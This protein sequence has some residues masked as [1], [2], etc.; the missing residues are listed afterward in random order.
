MGAV[1]REPMILRALEPSI[2][3]SVLGIWM[4]ILFF[5]VHLDLSRKW[6]GRLCPQYVV[7]DRG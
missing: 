4:K 7:A 3:G 5:E 6:S 2:P 1:V